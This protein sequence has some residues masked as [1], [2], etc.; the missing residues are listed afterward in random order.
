MLAVFPPSSSGHL[1]LAYAVTVSDTNTQTRPTALP[2][3]LRMVDKNVQEPRTVNTRGPREVTK[4]IWIDSSFGCKIQQRTD[5]LLSA[6]ESGVFLTSSNV[7]DVTHDA[8]WVCG[9]RYV[10]SVAAGD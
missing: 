1:Y 10:T 3:P 5:C 2:G 7:D 6:T 9:R 4:N 8:C